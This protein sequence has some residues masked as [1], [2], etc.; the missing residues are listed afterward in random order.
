M[1]REQW[2]CAAAHERGGVQRTAATDAGTES[3]CRMRRHASTPCPQ[4]LPA[5]AGQER[6]IGNRT[7][8]ALLDLARLLGAKPRRLRRQQRQLAQVPFSSDR[9]RMTT[10][11]LPPGHEDRCAALLAVAAFNT[12]QAQLHPTWPPVSAPLPTATCRP[13]LQPRRQPA[14]PCLHQR[15]V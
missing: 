1:V 10:A 8:I 13:T 6:R 12:T 15:G 7:E 14:V 4:L 5:P 2:D 11:S 9:K 3:G